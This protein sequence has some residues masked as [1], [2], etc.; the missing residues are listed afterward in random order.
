MTKK[1]EPYGE[2]PHTWITGPD[3]YKHSMYVPWMRMKAQ[4][5]FRGEEWNLPFEDFFNAW[6]GKWEN[7]GRNSDSL[8]MT[9]IDYDGIW[10]KD[11]IIIITR[12]EHC[13]KQKEYKTRM[14]IYKYLQPK[15]YKKRGRPCKPVDPNAPVKK[16]RVYV[17]KGEII[18]K[19]MRK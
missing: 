18:Y 9:R 10:S 14:G 16:K 4:A 3:E 6:N 15:E 7:R 1:R 12:K 5:A 17:K 11:N 8:C 19:K 2:R 13:S